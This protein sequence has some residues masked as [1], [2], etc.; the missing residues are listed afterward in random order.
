MALSL[1]LNKKYIIIK[2]LNKLLNYMSIKN[3]LFIALVAMFFALPTNAQVDPD[4]NPGMIISDAELLN[5][6]GMNL[7]QIQSFLEK[8]GSYLANYKTLNAHGTLKSAAEIIYEAATSN[9]DCRDA[10][11]SDNPTEA[12]K[13]MLCKR[14][15]T[16]NPRFLLVLLQKEA[17]LVEDRNPSQGRLDWATGYGCPDNWTCNPYYKG[18]GKQVNSA[19]LQFLAYMNSPQ[20]Y[21]FR[22]GGTYTFNNPF[23]TIS[24]EKMTVTIENQATAALY[25]YTPHV[26][27]GNYNVYRLYQRYFPQR[28]ARYPNGSL[29]QAKNE[30]GVWLIQEGQKRPFLS[31]V[32]LTSRYDLNKILIVDPIELEAYD[33]GNPISLP[34]YSIVKSP[35]GSLYLIVGDQKRMFANNEVFRSFGFNPAEIIEVSSQDLSYYK[36]GEQL[37]AS[38]MYPT[39]ALLQDPRSGGVY[40]VENGYK[41][42]ISDRIFLETIY[43]NRQ[44]LKVSAEEIDRYPAKAPV[45]F[46]DGE[47]L[48]SNSANTVY[49]IANGYKRPFLSGDDFENMGYQWSNII[50]VSPQILHPYPTGLPMN[51]EVM[52]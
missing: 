41:S 34:N 45:K 21:N 50:D 20:R 3:F 19:S 7:S 8:H 40:F 49:L 35:E 11:L 48:K 32:A 47:L 38:S 43:R 18:F 14:I 1:A 42:P 13:Q 46:P 12:E 22:A 33:K 39:G 37:T 28:T 23:G 51:Y 10:N 2:S 52:I 30:P 4:F 5:H 44:I 26:F 17:S 25:N 27:N 16:V 29:L 36:E 15:T 31:Q 24:Q 9:Y 6:N